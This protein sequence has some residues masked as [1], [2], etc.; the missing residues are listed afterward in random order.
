MNVVEE[1]IDDLNAV[2]RITITPDDYADKVN[3]VIN[4]YRKQANIPGFRPGKIPVSLI[5]KKYGKSILAEELN[6]VVN[7]SINDFI[8]TNKLN[9]LG[10]PLPKIND[11]VKGDFA[12]PAEFEFAYE[13]GLAPEFDIT[14]SKKNKFDYLKV[15]INDEIID[16]EVENLAKRYGS[17]V[18]ADKAGEKDMVLGEFSQKEGDI[19]NT[20][21][22]SLEFL[23]DKDAK[24]LFVDKK[25]GDVVG[26]DPRAVSK[27]DKDMAAMLGI[28]VENLETA[29]GDF[30]FKI[31]EIKTMVPAAIDQALFD[32][33]F[34][35]GTVKSEEELRTNISKDLEKMFGND[36]DRLFSQT[37]SDSLIEKTNFDL[38]EEFLKRWIMATSEKEISQDEINADFGN[39]AKSLKWQLIQSKIIKDNG[40]KVENQEIVDYTKGIIINQY[41]QY[42]M[43]APED[44]ALE[45]QAK[46]VLQNKEE[47]EKIYDNVY[48]AKMLHF[49][50]QTVKLNEKLMPYDDF[51]KVAYGQN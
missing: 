11:E 25:A 1:K 30:D 23:E 15:D 10:N 49:F 51:V 4:D 29:T 19:K 47:A 24:K 39:Y 38:P 35:E 16:K 14:L 2:L 18:S 45:D 8:T 32:K 42:G 37:I 27:D 31:T 3:K 36:S 22:I 50:K 46:N 5:K 17:L 28:E 12:N 40:I 6:K 44:E 9:I 43:P 7:E 48:G 20:T 41:A 21:T 26:V 33:L 34:G 13:I